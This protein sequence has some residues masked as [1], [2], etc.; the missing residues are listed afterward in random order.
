MTGNTFK[1]PRRLIGTQIGK[2]KLVEYIGRGTVGLVYRAIREDIDDTVA[3]K[4][5]PLENL[6]EEW[7][8]ELEKA[9]KLNGIEQVVSYRS[10]QSEII[11]GKP[12]VCIFWQFIKGQNLQDY[13]ETNSSAITLTFIQHLA[14]QLL[15]VLLAM[16]EVG[17]S[18]GDLH[19]GNILIAEPDPRLLEESVRIKV[20]D[21]GIGYS[22]SLAGPMDDY[23]SLA[24]ICHKLLARIDPS[25]L[26]GKARFLFERS[27]SFLNK[28]VL[29]HDP[30]VADYVR[31]PR[32]LI[33]RLRGFGQEYVDECQ[34]RLRLSLKHPFDY[35]SCEQI[36]DDFEL[37]HRLYSVQFLG[38][39]DLVERVNT[40]LT[41]PR[42]CGKTTVFRN[43][44]L[45]AQLLAEATKVEDIDDY[46]GIYYQCKDLYYAF[47]YLKEESTPDILQLTVH[48]FNLALLLQT[49]D[50]LMVV[51]RMSQTALS[52]ENLAPLETFIKHELPSYQ[53]PPRGVPKLDHMFDFAQ[54]E[55]TTFKKSLES[56][57][58]A[59]LPS[60]KYLGLDFL[61]RFCGLLQQTIPWLKDRPFY[62]FL[63]D[64][65]LPKISRSLQ[66]SL[67]RVIF[68]R[69]A[70]CYFKISTESV[71]TVYPYDADGKLLEQARE[72]D[73]IDLGDYFLH[74][75]EGRRKF[76]LQI[77]NN[78]LDRTESI[79]S[80]YKDIGRILGRTPYTYNALA[81][82]I[83]EG[84]HVYYYGIDTIVDLCSGDV[85]NI[86]TLLRDIFAGAGGPDAF[87]KPGEFKP[88]LDKEVQDRAIR[89]FGN[90]FLTRIE[91]IPETGSHLSKITEAFGEVAHWYLRNRTSK[92]V[93][94]KPQWQAFRIEIRDKPKFD[95]PELQRYYDDLIRY[96]VFIRDA[97]G[98]SQRGAVVPRLY[99]RRIL[100][101]TFR[102]TFNQRD[103]IGL[104]VDD[105]NTLLRDP[106]RFKDIMKAKAR[107]P[108]EQR[109]M[110]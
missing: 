35:L 15:Q 11:D 94:G 18:H 98:K 93:K 40:V 85:A 74:N 84:K 48:Y 25:T 62:F 17:I 65:S 49:L 83:K 37:L 86:L 22:Q 24:R 64:Y 75:Q 101:P 20:T 96:G 57:R 36:G 34:T 13:A 6:K 71:V 53:I 29:E 8:T 73:L 63:D 26:N 108:E 38:N 81:T 72:Y 19:E 43:L 70:E 31:N 109:R 82:D 21:F 99:L 91:S 52:E 97:R 55:K 77:I 95:E 1:L 110:L 3:C 90:D 41:G 105:F 32:L 30:L 60:E 46:I 4:I 2:Y 107:I 87:A 44:S 58:Y 33:T 23:A 50:T 68:D 79:S 28:E 78:R 102:L 67:N 56:G 103:N 106:E 80:D 5:V 100:I 51:S 16:K 39:R 7:E 66:M 12:C 92:N 88:P 27:I 61:K 45:K 42:G 9:C 104:E 10:H 76:L 54:R 59:I 89:E 14:N 47:P 69:W